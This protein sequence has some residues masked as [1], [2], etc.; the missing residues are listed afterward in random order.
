MELCKSS[1]IQLSGAR[2]LRR[3]RVN[4]QL[5]ASFDARTD[6]SKFSFPCTLYL[7]PQ[8]VICP[9]VHRLTRFSRPRDTILDPNQSCKEI[10]KKNL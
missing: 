5:R 8:L 1:G 2:C 7:P 10:N 4:K 3:L 9:P 6:L